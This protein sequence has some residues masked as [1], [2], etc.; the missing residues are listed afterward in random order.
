M[1]CKVGHP[2]RIAKNI[3]GFQKAVYR[4]LRK[5][6]NRLPVLFASANLYMLARAA[7]YPPLRVFAPFGRVPV[8]VGATPNEGEDSRETRDYG[9]HRVY[10]QMARVPDSMADTIDPSE[11][12]DKLVSYLE[13]HN[14]VCP[15]TV[16]FEP[17][18]VQTYGCPCG[19]GTFLYL[20][21]RHIA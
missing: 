18:N 21:I 10:I 14:S 15:G 16:R 20:S 19:C 5:N 2:C 8:V 1:R 3:F 12:F 9:P 6:L 13:H 7:L 4:G 17:Y 11:A